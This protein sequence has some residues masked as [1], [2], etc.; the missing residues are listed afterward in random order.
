MS[1][2]A[3]SLSWPNA[4]RDIVNLIEQAAGI[5]PSSKVRIAAGSS[6]VSTRAVSTPDREKVAP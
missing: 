4:A 1:M 6:T 5:A 2:A 3:R